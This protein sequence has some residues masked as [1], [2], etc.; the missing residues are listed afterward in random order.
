MSTKRRRVPPVL[1]RLFH[2]RARTLGDTIL[3]LVP[4]KTSANCLCKGRQCLGCVGENGATSF[5]IREKDPDNYRKLLNKCFVVLSDSTPPLR[6]YDPHCR[7]S[8]LELVRRTIEMTIIEQPSNVICFGYDKMS[9]FSDIVELL[10]SPAWGLLLKRIGDV[11]MVHLLKNTSIF[12]RLPRNK[13]RQVAGVPICDLRRKSLLHV[14]ATTYKLSLLHP[15]SRKKRSVDEVYSSMRKKMCIRKNCAAE[16]LSTETTKSAC[17]DVLPSREGQFYSITHTS[18]CGKR[19]RQYKWERQRKRKQLKAQEK[20][21]LIPCMNSNTKDNWPG[22]QNCDKNTWCSCCLVFQTI[23]EVKKEVQISRQTIFYKLESFPSVFPSK[24]I[25]NSLKPDA[26]G[27]NRLFKEIFGSLGVNVTTQIA[28]C[29]H[30][31]NCT[32]IRSTCLYHSIIKLLK[33]LIRKAHHCQ[34]V[35]LLEKHCST[36][37]LDQC[38]KSIIATILE[39]HETEAS[40]LAKGCAESGL[41]HNDIESE[42]CSTTPEAQP[43]LLEPTKCYCLK[44]QVVSFIWAVCRSIVPINLLG[45]PPNWRVLT[46]NISKLV[47]LRRFE[48]FTLKQSMRKIKLSRYPLL[49]DQYSLLKHKVLEHWIFWFFS[50]IVV[51]LVQANF[52]V[53][54]AEHEKQDIFY[55]RKPT[56]E[57]IISKFVTCLR[58]QGYQELN[59][60]SVKKII[61]NRSFGFSKV[62]LCPKG[63][64]VRMLANLKASA[65]LPVNP[66]LQSKGL[67]KVGVGRND[68]CCNYK[69]VNEVLKDLHVVLKRIVVNEPER[70]GSSVFDYNDAYK[71]LVPF[72]SLIK[73]EFSVKPGV[74]IIVS[75]VEKAFDSVDQ[76][77]LLSVLDDLNLEEEYILSKVVQVVCTKKS[78]RIPQKW[79]LVSKENA[80]DSANARSCLPTGSLHGILVKQQVQG[81]KVRK[82][83]LQNDLKEHIKR[84]VLRLGSNFFVQS[85]GIPQGSVLS[86]MLC[87]LYLGHLEKSV[88]FPFL[89]KACE[90]APGFPSEE[91]F[92]DDTAS[93]CAHLLMCKPSYLLLRFIDD[94]LF[95]STSKEQASRF[96]S[97][98]QRGFRAYNC[99]MNK[100]KFGMNFQI[101]TIPDPRSDRLYVVEDGTSFLRWSGLFINCST[102]EIQADYTRY[103]NFPLSSTLTV[104]WLNKPGRDLKVK[105]CGYLR[106]KCHPIFYDSNIN[107]AAVVRLNIYQAFLLC[108][109]KFHCYVFDLSS[110]CRFSTKFYADALGKSLR[111]MKKLIKRRM[112]SFKTGSDFRPILEVGKGEIEW[113]GLTAYIRVLKRKQ[114]RYKELLRVLDSKLMALGKQESTLSVLQEA[115]DDKRSSILWKIKY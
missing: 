52:Y 31:S 66:P 44:K 3:S 98:L 45:T 26:S 63:K 112:F 110:I 94:L 78:L 25:L 36:Q 34:H 109:M 115:T 60:A 30:S 99:D 105:L 62:R 16:K 38:S 5:L 74:F 11:L 42:S 55:Y 48:K 20:Y 8:H 67:R 22:D 72:L 13:H 87:S 29:T 68:K 80:P 92:L 113:L 32:F 65:K 93:G 21:S 28:S 18:L 9:R 111:Y 100:K 15:E 102:L 79:T 108:A 97:R 85:V 88:I 14:S 89:D 6:V 23:P 61:W 53:T 83:Q 40:I 84:N 41:S 24:H 56:W 77:K 76:D 91:C 7:W 90:P 1:W 86:S 17:S 73:S 2:N 114:S 71:R 46:K 107:S 43:S 10:T 64:G 103:L 58:D 81:R 101:N 12:F 49:S 19:K 95:I 82:E 75:D 27:A 59:V 106:P 47:K 57:N 4:S 69:S 104:C 54:E 50:S 33:T 37:S 96:F 70:L 51:P 39:R 35:R